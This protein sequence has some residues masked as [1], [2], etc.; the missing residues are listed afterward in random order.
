MKLAGTAY[1]PAWIDSSGGKTNIL[2]SATVSANARDL[3]TF[4]RAA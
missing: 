4:A 2:G 3:S 1:I